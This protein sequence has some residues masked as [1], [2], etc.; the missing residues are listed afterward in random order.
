MFK[1]HVTVV[2]LDFATIDN[3]FDAFRLVDGALVGAI[4]ALLG[5]HMLNPFHVWV[6]KAS[7]PSNRART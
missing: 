4:K 1:C 6:D 2:D 3:D 7:I 5:F